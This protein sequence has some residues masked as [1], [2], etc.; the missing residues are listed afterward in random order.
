MDSS[1]KPQANERN[2]RKG[3]PARADESRQAPL[4]PMAAGRIRSAAM[5]DM[6]RAGFTR[7]Q[8]ADKFGASLK[9]VGNILYN[10]KAT[11]PRQAEL[12]NAIKDKANE[13]AKAGFTREEIAYRLGA[14]RATV[15]KVLVPFKRGIARLE[16]L[17]PLDGSADA[18]AI[19][20][21]RA[22]ILAAV[23]Y[24]KASK[25]FADQ[26]LAHLAKAEGRIR[27]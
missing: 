14:S 15:D 5:A 13:L 2:P 26:A 25:P 22:R 16:H 11:A 17:F 20:A 27:Q 19:A 21:E 6:A 4:G 7:S 24:G 8:I 18:D 23:R 3:N 9:T 10:A 1:I 12:A